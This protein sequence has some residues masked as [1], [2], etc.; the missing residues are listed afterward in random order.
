MSYKIVLLKEAEYDLD[1]AF[2]WYEMQKP[3]LGTKFIE[4]ID[5]GFQFITFHPKASPEKIEFVRCHI[6]KKFPFGIYYKLN[7]EKKEIQIIAVLHFKRNQKML[8]QR[9]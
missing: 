4:Y 6:I 5:K 2:L 9:I 8:D 3:L 1:D 7:E